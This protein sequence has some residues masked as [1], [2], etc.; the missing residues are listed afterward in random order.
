MQSYNSLIKAMT[1][2]NIMKPARKVTPI[3]HPLLWWIN[4][5]MDRPD[6]TVFGKAKNMAWRA[7]HVWVSPRQYNYIIYICVFISDICNQELTDKKTGIHGIQSSSP[8]RNDQQH[9][10]ELNNH[11]SNGNKKFTKQSPMILFSPAQCCCHGAAVCPSQLHPP[12]KIR[13]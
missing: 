6:V 9:A 4:L 1:F 2:L 13:T 3:D 12:R 8:P 7:R 5:H 10:F 11:G